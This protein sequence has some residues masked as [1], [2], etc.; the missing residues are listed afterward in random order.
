MK[1]G[2]E[3]IS[4]THG[5]FP[6]L[7]G[8]VEDLLLYAGDFSPGRGSLVET[9]KFLDWLDNQPHKRKILVAGNHDFICER[10]PGL[11]QTL[12]NSHK[13]ITYLKD[14]QTVFKGWKIYGSPWQPW[15][16]DWAFNAPRDGEK[17][18]QIWAAIPNDT[19]ILVTHSPPY[20][21]MDQCPE[22]VG[23][24]LLRDRVLEVKPKVHCFG[25]IHQGEGAYL[26]VYPET[27]HQQSTLFV[28]AS[29]VD[30]HYQPYER[31]ADKLF[32]GLEAV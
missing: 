18:R 25:H 29:Y 19:D 3:C 1:F 21:I 20:G 27:G 12:V 16:Y 10:D 2:I 11:F 24:K 23:C 22:H 32:K 17:L 26:K 5:F 8:G 28:N 4:D 15:F 31:P 14:S 6:E 30:E 13:S 7:K 9:I